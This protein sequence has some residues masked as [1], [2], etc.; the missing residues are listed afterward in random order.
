M[1]KSIYTINKEEKLK[2]YVEKFDDK[3]HKDDN[4]GDQRRASSNKHYSKR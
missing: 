2:R 1:A 4:G 3:K